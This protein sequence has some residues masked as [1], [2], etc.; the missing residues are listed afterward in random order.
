MSLLRRVLPLALAWVILQALPA[1][2]QE[3]SRFRGPNGTGLAPSLDV[4]DSWTADDFAWTAELPGGGHS[5][6]VLWG[7]R[8][9]LTAADEAAQKR[10]A[11]CLDVRDGHV[12]WTREYPLTLHDRHKFNSFASPTAAADEERVYFVWSTPAEYTLLALDHDGHD[13]WRRDLGP[14]EGQHSC[15]TS[16]IVYEELVILGNDQDGASSLVAVDRRTGEDRWQA[17]RNTDK[18]AYSTPCVYQPEGRG[19]ELIFNSG[20]HGI[21]GIDPA[22]GRS[23]WEI[24]VFDKR[25]VSSPI[26][27]AG[28]VFGSCGSGGGGN[29]VVAV[30]PGEDSAGAAP[31][32]AY[33]V[34]DQAPYVPTPLAK[35]DLVFLWSDKGFV[36]C[37]DAATAQVHWRQRVGGNFFGS[38]ICAGDRLICVSAEGEAVVLKASKEFKEL[39]RTQFAD[40]LCHTTPAVA[41]GRLY[42]R[43]DR[44]VYAIGK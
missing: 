4:P 20:A 36:A 11:L 27:A 2:A 17:P 28:L 38:P 33:R 18:V 35:D 14:Y 24:K 13:V 12:L 32:L 22:S 34:D 43:T 37:L 19:P 21:S 6:P 1:A 9:F 25:S 42:I 30:R 31:E 5:S 16:P 40:T 44:H 10:L 7:E 8:M 3:W 15:G 41:G 29:Y 23:L 26:V 39:G